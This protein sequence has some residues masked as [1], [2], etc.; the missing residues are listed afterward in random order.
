MLPKWPHDRRIQNP[1]KYELLLRIVLQR[2][3]S[4]GCQACRRGEASPRVARASCPWTARSAAHHASP[5]AG[6]TPA[7][8]PERGRDA[9]ATPGTRAR[10]PRCFRNTRETPVPQRLA[11]PV[12]EMLPTRKNPSLFICA[13]PPP[14]AFSDC[15]TLASV[16]I[17][18]A[19]VHPS[20]NHPQS[21]KTT[22][23]RHT[24]HGCL[25]SRQRTL[26]RTRR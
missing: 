25:Q 15:W 8:R 18:N 12:F 4:A 19:P 14:F 13:T 3:R 17:S 16:S 7:L 11:C 21:P 22:K 2:A 23:K 9:R 26:R 6:E 5:D 24:H 10:R 1:R 20:L